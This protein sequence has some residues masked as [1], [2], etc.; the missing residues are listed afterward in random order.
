MIAVRFI[1]IGVYFVGLVYGLPILARRF[2]TPRK[3][4]VSLSLRP[5]LVVFNLWGPLFWIF[6]GVLWVGLLDIS[7][8]LVVALSFL[9]PLCVLRIFHFAARVFKCAYSMTNR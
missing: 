8:M 2:S 5:W 7:P 4:S 1:I 9:L 3:R 6:P